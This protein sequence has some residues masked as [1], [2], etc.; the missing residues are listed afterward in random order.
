MTLLF[1]APAFVVELLAKVPHL[2]SEILEYLGEPLCLL[3]IVRLDVRLVG[4]RPFVWSRL[5]ADQTR[6]VGVV[7]RVQ[8]HVHLLIFLDV[9][10]GATLDTPAHGLDG[11]T[12]DL[13]CLLHGVAH[14]TGRV[15][16]R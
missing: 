11:E 3:R 7:D 8:D 12:Q 16:G 13:G 9:I 15:T 14:A 10:E 1:A 4:D 2:I 5:V 6:P